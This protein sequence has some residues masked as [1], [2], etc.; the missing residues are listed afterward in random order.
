MKLIHGITLDLS[1]GIEKEL[2]R[3]EWSKIKD[4]IETTMS[5]K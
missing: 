2:K 1:Y 3:S 4:W 5:S